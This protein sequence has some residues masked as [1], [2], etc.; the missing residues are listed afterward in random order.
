MEGL[1]LE[2]LRLD[3]NKLETLRLGCAATLRELSLAENRIQSLAG[4]EACTALQEL[5][6]GFNLVSDFRE[7]ERLAGLSLLGTLC[8][9]GNPVEAGDEGGGNFLYR[10]RVLVRLQRLHHLDTCLVTAE[11]KVKAVNIH[12][13]EGSDLQ[14]RLDTHN[15]FFPGKGFINYLPPCTPGAEESQPRGRV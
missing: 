10:M 9:R 14:N 4:L 12:G 8:L 5:D 11:E 2:K 6:M 13:C 7:V 3:A 1:A 15:K